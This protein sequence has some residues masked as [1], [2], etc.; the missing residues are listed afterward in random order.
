MNPIGI[1]FISVLGQPPVDFV[2]DAA[3]LGVSHIGMAPAPIVTVPGLY[4]AWSLVDDAPLRREVKEALAER[5]VS[6]SVG[7]G[8]LIWPDR[9]ISE[10]GA[11]VDAMAELG[12]PILNA[13]SVDPDT[14]RGFDQLAVFAEMAAARGLRSAIEFCP[15]TGVPDLPTALA[16]VRHVGRP[17]FKLLVDS[18]HLFRSGSKAEDLAALDPELIGYVQICDVPFVSRYADYS[19][20]ARFDR[21]AP[22]EGELPLRDMIAA[23]PRDI[24]LGVELPMRAKAEAGIGP[25]GRLRPAIEATRM[26]VEEVAA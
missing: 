14:G 19:E 3:E 13:V 26:L 20:E 10:T 1:E 18:M 17:D 11:G 7:E 24:L 25:V 9:D 22:G 6:L 5:G 15:G 2:H 21:L 4:P 16:A 12:A 8:F 23:L